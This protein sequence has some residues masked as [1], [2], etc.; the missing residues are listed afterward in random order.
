MVQREN[1]EE[2]ERA[3]WE[4]TRE[5]VENLRLT[6]SKYT[7]IRINGK[8]QRRF[9]QY[10]KTMGVIQFDEHGNVSIFNPTEYHRL[11]EINEKLETIEWHEKEAYLD[12]HPEEQAKML[13]LRKKMNAEMYAKFGIKHEPSNN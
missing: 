2:Q 6:L 3:F 11:N 7:Q 8:L 4:P 13:E 12:T 1:K 9:D 10:C 5:E